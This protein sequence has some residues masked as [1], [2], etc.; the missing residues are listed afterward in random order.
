M[1][2]ET[3]DSA[4]AIFLDRDG[5]I[6]RDVDY[7]DD[8][9]DVEI[10]PGVADALR[11]LK[12]AGYKIIIVT[13][14]SGIGRGYFDETAYRAVEREVERQLG[15]GV[16][17]AT[18]FCADGPEAASDRRK[19]GIGMVLEAQRDHRLDL[20]RSF[21]LGD[22]KSDIDC[23]RGAGLQTVLVRTGYGSRENDCTPDFIA[24]DV[25]AAA[26]IIISRHNG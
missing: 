17:D 21:M 25:P 11:R 15:G 18:Y 7:C 3:D 8:P 6:M 2:R 16:V 19:P 4:P 23:G 1:T 5:T 9:G 24:A 10:L 20:T 12:G 26:E 14:Q 22:K 13:N